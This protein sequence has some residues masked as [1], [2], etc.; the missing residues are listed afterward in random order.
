MKKAHKLNIQTGIWTLSEAVEYI[1]AKQPKAHEIGWNLAL[2]GGVLNNGY[3]KRDLDIFA[4]RRTGEKAGNRE[5]DDLLALFHLP[6]D[7]RAEWFLGNPD[8]YGFSVSV[9][10]RLSTMKLKKVELVVI[11]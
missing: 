6:H 4:V 3:S 9:N 2:G 1:R 7:T 11:I 10:D 8:R 5:L